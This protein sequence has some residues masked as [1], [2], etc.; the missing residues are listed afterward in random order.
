MKAD[1]SCAQLNSQGGFAKVP[2]L[3]VKNRDNL[4]WLKGIDAKGN[5]APL[6]VT[7]PPMSNTH[8]GTP[9]VDA[10]GPK[11]IFHNGDNSGPP[12]NNAEY[13]T[14]LYQRV[15]VGGVSCTNPQDP[16]VIIEK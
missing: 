8:L 7:F 10:N 13:D 14:Y 12:A 2:P 11:F 16:G 6:V 5:D 4:T 3:S 9:F 1:N 15:T